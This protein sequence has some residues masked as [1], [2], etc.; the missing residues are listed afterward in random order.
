[1]NMMTNN[2]TN[3]HSIANMNISR[4]VIANADINTN[5]SIRTKSSTT[6]VTD[7]NR[8]YLN[9]PFSAV[10]FYVIDVNMN[11]PMSA[12]MYSIAGHCNSNIHVYL[13]LF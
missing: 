1:M 13:Y 4:H 6:R 3:T 9:F 8:T 5:M 12:I 10:A 11:I 7:I 2:P